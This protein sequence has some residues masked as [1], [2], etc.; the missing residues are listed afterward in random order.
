MPILKYKLASIIAS[1]VEEGY[2]DEEELEEY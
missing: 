2:I 1:L